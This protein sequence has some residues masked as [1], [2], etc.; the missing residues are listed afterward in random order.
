MPSFNRSSHAILAYPTPCY[1]AKNCA[2]DANKFCKEKND[3]LE[4]ASVL[5]CL[6][7][8]PMLSHACPPAVASVHEVPATMHKA[9]P[10]ALAAKYAHALPLCVCAPLTSPP[11]LSLSLKGVL[12]H[13]H[14]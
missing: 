7:C 5:S 12:A 10:A 2:E 11:P 13:T 3:A 8:A 14:L 4:P 6:R 1:A 9:Y